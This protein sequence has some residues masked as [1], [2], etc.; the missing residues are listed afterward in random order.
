MKVNMKN[1]KRYHV[2]K[3]FPSSL[4]FPKNKYLLKYSSH[5]MKEANNDIYRPEKLSLPTFIDFSNCFIFEIETENDLL[6]KV[7]CRC[8][9][10]DILDLVLCI[11]INGYIVNTVWFNLRTDS[12]NNIDLS[13][14]NRPR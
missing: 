4:V 14:Y 10:N 12:H 7:L 13:K 2:R 6:N 3:G 1:F 11:S 8:Q 5:A 9:Y